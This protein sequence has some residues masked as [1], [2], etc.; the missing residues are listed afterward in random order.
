[1]LLS[2]RRRAQVVA[3]AL[4]LAL[5][6]LLQVPSL[7]AADPLGSAFPRPEAALS[8]LELSMVDRTNAD[9]IANGVEPM[10]VDPGLLEI[11]RARAAAQLDQPQLTHYDG[12][13]QLAFVGLLRDFGVDYSLAGENLARASWLD[14]SMLD[15][16]EQALMASPLHRK[17]I[18]DPSFNRLAIGVASGS[19]GQVVF[20]EIFRATP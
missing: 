17:N 19:S 8:P 2:Y 10:E 16:I 4:A 20:A 14:A 13:G 9:R 7:V 15:R 5:T 11:A 6:F 12:S 18:L 3:A 1:M